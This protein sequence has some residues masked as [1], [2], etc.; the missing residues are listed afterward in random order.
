MPRCAASRR[1][2]SRDALLLAS[3]E[4]DEALLGPS[5]L[6]FEPRR[7]VY[8]EVLRNALDPFLSTFDGPNPVSTQGR[9]A[10][11]NVPAQALTM[12]NDLFVHA[13]TRRLGERLGG[14][15]P[16]KR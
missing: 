8:V 11:T 10:E 1:R 16:T 14:D 2:P 12:M 7:S 9:R 3:G 6:G 4:L 5:V 13:Q 15:F